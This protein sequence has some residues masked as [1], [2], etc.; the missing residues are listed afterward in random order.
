MID[1]L[2]VVGLI[3]GCTNLLAVLFLGMRYILTP[4]EALQPRPPHLWS[5]MVF[6]SRTF[7]LPT[8][9]DQAR[10][11]RPGWQIAPADAAL[12]AAQAA[13]DQLDDQY[14]FRP[15]LWY[16]ILLVSP[17]HKRRGHVSD[18]AARY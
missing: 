6:E 13:D 7:A 1:P 8:L 10:L 17:H 14:A 5:A 12:I 16:L 15:L 3:M 2:H 18:A 11:A 4:H 9:A